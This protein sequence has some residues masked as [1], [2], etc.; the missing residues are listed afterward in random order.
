MTYP[1]TDAAAAP[2]Q[3]ARVEWCLESFASWRTDSGFD[4]SDAHLPTGVI[5]RQLNL[6][7]WRAADEHR[8]GKEP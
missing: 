5:Y 6:L 3:M 8:S 7:E 1:A 2:S 4:N